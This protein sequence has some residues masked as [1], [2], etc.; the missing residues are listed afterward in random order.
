MQSTIN[1][2]EREQPVA[3]EEPEE[4][5]CRHHWRIAAPNGA[6]SM[7]RCKICGSERE[8]SNSST[9]SIWEN[10][11]SDGGNRWRGRGRGQAAV[12]DVPA[13]TRTVAPISESTLGSLLGVGYRTGAE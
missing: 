1:V 10:D 11:S 7:G 2:M 13:A 6:T 9:D 3:G 12:T 5:G 4:P 8:F